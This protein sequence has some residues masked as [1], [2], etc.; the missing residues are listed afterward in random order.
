MRDIDLYAQIF[1]IRSPWQV[2][3]S[4]V[5]MPH[6][7]V[8]LRVES[9]VGVPLRCLTCGCQAP[10]YD[11]RRWCWRHLDTCQYKTILE[12]DAPSAVP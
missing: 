9:E 6:C 2:A 12:A 10:G 3:G 5:D 8:M 11:P 1:G 4:E 7:K